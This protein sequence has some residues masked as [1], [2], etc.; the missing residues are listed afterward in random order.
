MDTENAYRQQQVLNAIR[1]A[2]F[3]QANYHY[4]VSNFDF[5]PYDVEMFS[6]GNIN[7]TGFQIINRELRE[8]TLLRKFIDQS[9][10]SERFEK[11]LDLDVSGLL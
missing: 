5:Q 3:N 2:Q 9:R 1:S 11:S 4:V 8:F 7:I 6:S 10:R